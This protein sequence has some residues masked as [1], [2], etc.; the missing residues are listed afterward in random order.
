VSWF[1][2]QDGGGDDR[3]IDQLQADVMRFMAILGLILTIIFALVQSLPFH[4][5]NVAAEQPQVRKLQ[6]Q[7]THLQSQIATAQDRLGRIASEIQKADL[8][9]RQVSG[10]IGFLTSQEKKLRQ[11]YRRL[12]TRIQESEKALGAL[13]AA[14]MDRRFS[15]LTV[16]DRTRQ[17]KERLQG[18]QHQLAKLETLSHQ[19]KSKSPPR[20]AG[21]IAK[22]PP[23][24]EEQRP[25]SVR[26]PVEP[27]PPKAGFSLKFASDK[28]LD[29]LVSRGDVQFFVIAPPRAWQV[30]WGRTGL[31]FTA[32][33]PPREFHE[34]AADTVPVKY[35]RGFRHNHA[36]AD[37]RLTWAIVLPPRISREVRAVMAGE[38][39]GNII[40]RSDA[41]VTLQ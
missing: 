7:L 31:R 4:S 18:L 24:H 32:S 23:R 17:E 20:S 39:G 25:K 26:H 6:A 14:L 30:R 12:D 21:K 11:Q 2:Y 35:R 10:Q 37:T 28:A 16:Q 19:L 36:P 1:S 22:L 9:R 8:V 40:I 41:S 3:E 27:P 13:Q 15:L 5:N 29:Q 38:T 34:M 33:R